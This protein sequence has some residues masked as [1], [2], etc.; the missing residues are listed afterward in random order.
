MQQRLRVAEGDRNHD[1]G[2]SLDQIDAALKG[3]NQ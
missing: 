1:Y 2:L 3:G